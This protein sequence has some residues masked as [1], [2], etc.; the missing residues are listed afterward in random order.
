MFN[1][2]ID[3]KSLNHKSLEKLQWGC[4]FSMFALSN[5]SSGPCGVINYYLSVNYNISQ[6]LS[7]NFTGFEF[8]KKNI[9]KGYLGYGQLID[10][11]KKKMIKSN[12]L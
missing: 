1:T 12:F 9:E 10:K 7:Y 4:I 11:N 8:I 6:A 3:L 5:S 2:L